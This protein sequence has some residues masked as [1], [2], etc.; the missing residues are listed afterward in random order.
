VTCDNFSLKGPSTRTLLHPIPP[1]DFMQIGWR[2]DSLSDMKIEQNGQFCSTRFAVHFSFRFVV[3]LLREHY[4]CVSR[5]LVL[6]D[7][8]NMFTISCARRIGDDDE[9]GISV[10]RKIGR[11]IV[12]RIGCA[13]RMEILHLFTLDGIE[14]YSG[15]FFDL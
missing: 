7:K 1:D 4:E 15:C 9:E 14:I 5:N 12:Q 10:G 13:N 11:E 8:L 2:S 6:P 3:A